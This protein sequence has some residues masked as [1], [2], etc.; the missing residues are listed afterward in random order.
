MVAGNKN[1]RTSHLSQLQISLAQLF[2]ISMIQLNIP[3]SSLKKGRCLNCRSKQLQLY[4]LKKIEKTPCLCFT[5]SVELT[6]VPCVGLLSS[7]WPPST[8]ILRWVL[9]DFNSL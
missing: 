9:G 6:G 3:H 5:L 8:H 4:A 2:Y 1:M 7:F